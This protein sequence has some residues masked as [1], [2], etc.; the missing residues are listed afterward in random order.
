VSVFPSALQI[1]S[2]PIAYFKLIY[3]LILLNI[4]MNVQ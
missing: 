4:N 1:L 2:L 3:F